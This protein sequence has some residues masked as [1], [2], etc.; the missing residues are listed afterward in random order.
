MT[1]PSWNM[2][3][4]KSFRIGDSTRKQS[5]SSSRDNR[6]Y[7]ASSSS[8]PVAWAPPGLAATLL[9]RQLI[10]TIIELSRIECQKVANGRWRA[11]SARQLNIQLQQIDHSEWTQD[12]MRD[13][14]TSHDLW[15]FLQ[16]TVACY[17]LSSI[18]PR[19]A[20]CF[21]DSTIIRTRTPRHFTQLFA[22][23]RLEQSA[24]GSAGRRMSE[25]CIA[26]DG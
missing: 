21:W 6:Q 19:N 26:N 25:T 14:F 1:N 15:L 24:W 9:N 11:I 7:Y 4:S 20:N 23:I 3:F 8:D 17:S 22:W 2:S 10:V 18:L 5:T 12:F 16:E 13:K